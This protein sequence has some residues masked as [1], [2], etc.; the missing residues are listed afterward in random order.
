MA[1]PLWL[2]ITAAVVG[3]LGGGA[4][5]VSSGYNILVAKRTKDDALRGVISSAWTNEG[6]ISSPE[7]HFVT[8]QLELIDGDIIGQI[9]TNAYDR[10]LEAHVDL[11]FF[12]IKLMI[13]E[14]LGRSLVPVA[15]VRLKLK[16][17]RN[18]LSWQVVSGN[19]QGWLPTRTL[20]WPSSVGL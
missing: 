8:V 7:T 14:L 18:R 12:N 13:T 20:L 1:L 11:G 4:G 3:I 9:R 2:Q 15:V 10:L 17:N 6:D 16:G 19:K 5:F